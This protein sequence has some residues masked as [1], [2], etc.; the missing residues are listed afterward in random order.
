MGG[1]RRRG[2]G[3][4]L[5]RLRPDGRDVRDGGGGA[6]LLGRSAEDGGP[7]SFWRG[8]GR[9]FGLLL[10]SLPLGIGLVMAGFTD[11]KRALHDM[12]CSTLVVDRWAFTAQPERQRTDLGVVTIVI[13]VLSLLGLVAYIGLIGVFIAAMGAGMASH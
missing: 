9:Y 4:A 13:I 11:R 12:V 8:F 6:L 2:R 1:V 3:A 5:R 10:S 7:I